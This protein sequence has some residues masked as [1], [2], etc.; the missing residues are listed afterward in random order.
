MNS[1]SQIKIIL[2]LGVLVA[3]AGWLVADFVVPD[4]DARKAAVGPLEKLEKPM[5]RAFTAHND[6]EAKKEPQ[7]ADWLAQHEEPGQT[8]AQYLASGP[9]RPGE[10]GRMAL[11][12]LPLGKFEKETSQTSRLC[13]VTWSSSM[14]R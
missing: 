10:D 14:R 7:W 4:G 1:F 5:Q 2:P 6:F 12:V 8:F 9:N 3:A 11:Y 13:S